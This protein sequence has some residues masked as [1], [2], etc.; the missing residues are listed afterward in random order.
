MGCFGSSP[1][2]TKETVESLN[3]LVLSSSLFVVSN[4][5]EF[6]DV[7]QLSRALGVG[8]FG[9]VRLC[10]HLASGST[11]AVK[12]FYRMSESVVSTTGKMVHELEILKKLDHP[13]II[14]VYESFSDRNFYYI[15][16][17]HCSGGELFQE[18]IKQQRFPEA[19][20]AQIMK[21]IFSAVAYLHD[22]RI[23][24]RDLKPENI[25]FEDK[26]EGVF[27]K[28]IDFGTS[29]QIRPNKTVKGSVGSAYYIAPEVLWGTY[30]EKCDV[31]SAGVI[32]YIL[33]CGHP[34]FHGASDDE[35]FSAIRKGKYDFKGAAW[36]AVSSQACALLG[37]LLVPAKTRISALEALQDP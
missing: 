18:I 26:T 20:C 12:L 36:A 8:T 9:E 16:M 3:Q 30:T 34:P 37:K 4:T 24:H 33:L 25:L 32:M 5:R 23:V 29:V 2:K 19:K 28:L 21:Q 22:Q 13:N 11:R 17:E 27:L 1:P 7:Y 10:T 14:R 31:W 6:K 15:V 35:I